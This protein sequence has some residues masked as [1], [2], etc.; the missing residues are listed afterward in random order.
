MMI[1]Y[2]DTQFWQ[3]K[4]TA[5]G[6]ITGSTP[7]GAGTVLL[8]VRKMDIYH[9]LSIFLTCKSTVPAPRGLEPVILPHDVHF[10]YL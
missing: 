10:P 9:M 8:Q 5:Y 3:G 2:K 4:W 6:G 1:Y 7:G